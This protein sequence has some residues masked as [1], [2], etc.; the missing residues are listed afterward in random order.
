MLDGIAEALQPGESGFLNDG[1]SEAMPAHVPPSSKRL[2][3]NR[4]IRLTQYPH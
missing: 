2:S 3:M 4:I 1:F